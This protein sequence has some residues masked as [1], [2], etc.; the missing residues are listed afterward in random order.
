MS[1]TDDV[2]GKERVRHTMARMEIRIVETQKEPGHVY[3]ECLNTYR[4][5]LA[6]GRDSLSLDRHVMINDA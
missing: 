3:S 4:I 5:N 6:K 2:L 1:K